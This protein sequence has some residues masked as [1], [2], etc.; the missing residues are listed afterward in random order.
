M[1]VI[2]FYNSVDK[3][4]IKK[5]E[6]ILNDKFLHFF[7]SF[8]LNDPF[9]CYVSIMFQI[10]SFSIV[11]VSAIKMYCDTSKYFRML[12]SRALSLSRLYHKVQFNHPRRETLHCASF[13][14]S[15]A[16]HITFHHHPPHIPLRR[17]CL[18]TVSSVSKPYLPKLPL[19]SLS[20]SH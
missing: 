10:P 20:P 16:F 18:G 4:F 6:G 1:T 2:V 19:S 3:T 9:I 13:I 15:T 5:T 14:A 12:N 8:T 17:M 11:K 7:V